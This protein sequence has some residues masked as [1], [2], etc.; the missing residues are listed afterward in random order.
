MQIAGV[1]VT[2]GPI[3]MLTVEGCPEK[4]SFRYLGN[5]VYSESIIYKASSTY[6]PLFYFQ[7]V[8]NF[9]QISETEEKNL[10][11][12]FLIFRYLHLD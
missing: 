10:D 9:M 2:L 1:L 12:V 7:N 11:S 3:S 8:L 5:H 4:G 6:E